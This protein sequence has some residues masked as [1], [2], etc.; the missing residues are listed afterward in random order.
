MIK[1]KLKALK[2]HVTVD[3]S[4]ANDIHSLMENSSNYFYR[5]FYTEQLKMQKLKGSS[6]RFHPDVIRYAAKYYVSFTV[7]IKIRHGNLM[8][9]DSTDFLTYFSGLLH[10]IDFY[11]SKKIDPILGGVGELGANLPFTCFFLEQH[12]KRIAFESLRQ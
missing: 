2:Q 11:L 1:E 6:C 9:F 10:R 4:V 12:Q 8:T 5:L 7:N 3:E